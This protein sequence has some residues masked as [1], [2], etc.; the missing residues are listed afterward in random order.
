MS[1]TKDRFTGGLSIVQNELLI[2]FETD[3]ADTICFA[4]QN[5]TRRA[6]IRLL[7]RKNDKSITEI[8]KTLKQTVSHI[9]YQAGILEK[10]GLLQANYSSASHG[11]VKC[12][13]LALNKIILVLREEETA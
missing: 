2:K 4:L 9:S 8:A 12:M 10:V 7:A 11:T 5:P 6:I 13:H 3:K 1:A